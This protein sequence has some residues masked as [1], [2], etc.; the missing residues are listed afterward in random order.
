MTA[1]KARSPTPGHSDAADT[2]ESSIMLP[3]AMGVSHFALVVPYGDGAT[4]LSA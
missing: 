3:G 2:P 1:L 4:N